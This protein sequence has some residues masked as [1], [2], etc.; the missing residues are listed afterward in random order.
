[1]AS[2]RETSDSETVSRQG[3]KAQRGGTNQ[4]TGGLVGFT[5]PTAI[6]FSNLS[7]LASLRET[8]D[9]ETVSRQGTEAQRG[10]TNSSITH[11][12]RETYASNR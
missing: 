6:S 2:L 8:S 7:G 9:S 11:L 3:A 4:N 1:L 12:T 5:T 10:G